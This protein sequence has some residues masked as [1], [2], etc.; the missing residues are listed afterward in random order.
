M[1]S[2]NNEYIALEKFFEELVYLLYKGVA[3]F[4]RTCCLLVTLK[5]ALL[6]NK[7]ILKLTKTKKLD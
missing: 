6:K 5:F 3:I 7:F 1:D 2:Y 4:S